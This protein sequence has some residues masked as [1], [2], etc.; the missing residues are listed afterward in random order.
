MTDVNEYDDNRSAGVTTEPAPDPL[1]E[2]VA[3]A[4]ESQ[5]VA[6]AAE[7]QPAA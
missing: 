2:P 1:G 3:E 7:S 5:P 6:Q 4:A